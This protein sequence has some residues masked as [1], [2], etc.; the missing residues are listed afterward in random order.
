[1]NMFLGDKVGLVGIFFE[2]GL[3]GYGFRIGSLFGCS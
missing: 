2:L 1:M 3:G